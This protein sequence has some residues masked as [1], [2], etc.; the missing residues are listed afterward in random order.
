MLTPL[1]VTLC[2]HRLL[3]PPFFLFFFFSLPFLACP[4]PQPRCNTFTSPPPGL[5]AFFLPLMSFCLPSSAVFKAL[6]TLPSAVTFTAP[7]SGLTMDLLGS[8]I[9]RDTWST[10]RSTGASAGGR[11]RISTPLSLELLLLQPLLQ[12]FPLLDAI[13]LLLIQMPL[14]DFPFFFFLLLLLFCSPL[15]G[16]GPG[17]DGGMLRSYSFCPPGFCFCSCLRFI[18]CFLFL[19]L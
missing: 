7:P 17:G 13:P 9:H 4:P 14:S 12:L 19:L 8:T 1:V 18:L 15:P 10:T 11:V 6:L 2:L 3:P 16:G 5:G